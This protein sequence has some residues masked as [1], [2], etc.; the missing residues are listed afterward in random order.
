MKIIKIK[1]LCS[2]IGKKKGFTRNIG[3]ASLDGSGHRMVNHYAGNNH[4]N[5][6]NYVSGP[7]QPY[8]GGGGGGGGS[9]YGK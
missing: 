9:G 3:Q 4:G 2:I 7:R 6:R 5:S 8:R 1:Y